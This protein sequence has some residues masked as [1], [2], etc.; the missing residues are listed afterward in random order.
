MLVY[1]VCVS[2]AGQIVAVQGSNDPSDEIPEIITALRKARVTAAGRRGD[3]SVSTAL[4]VPIP[5]DRIF[6]P[7]LD[8]RSALPSRKGTAAVKI[9]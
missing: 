1:A 3:V 6:H 8:A 4:M 7:H 5:V 2:E 9:K